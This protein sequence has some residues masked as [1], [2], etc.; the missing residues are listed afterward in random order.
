MNRKLLATVALGAIAFSS[1]QLVSAQVEPDS[2]EL[3]LL[4]SRFPSNSK[5]K[6][7]EVPIPLKERSG[8]EVGCSFRF[9]PSKLEQQGGC[10]IIANDKGIKIYKEHG[11][12]IELLEDKRATSETKIDSDRIFSFNHQ[13]WHK[14]HRWE[15]GFL[16]DD[17]SE[18]ANDTNFVVILTSEKQAESITNEIGSFASSKPELIENLIAA[19]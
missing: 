15:I 7:I 2:K 5:C 8:E 14:T 11:E 9:D 17:S 12:E 3:F 16:P 6:G 1:T 13:I 19:N 10:K 18:T 4:C